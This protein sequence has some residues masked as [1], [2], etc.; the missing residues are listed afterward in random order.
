M[1][2]NRVGRWLM[3]SPL[4]A[5]LQRRYLMPTYERMG[6]KFDDARVLE[7][8]CGRGIGMDLIKRAGAAR[9]DG[10]DLD[11]VMVKLARRR[12]A[13]RML[14]FVADIAALPIPNATYD[15]VVDFGAIHLM[16]E[17]RTA[18]SEVARV[19]RPGGRFLFEQPAHRVYRLV[20][21]LSTSRRIPGGFTRAAFL[22]EL[23]ECGF[24]ETTLVRPRFL[25]LTGILGDVVGVAVR[26]PVSYGKA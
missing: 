3:N 2:M 13:G 11:P 19:V 10:A 9:V 20:M 1:R 7:V 18:V 5:C 6:A 15:V 21:P 14:V 16:P 17:W 24:R 4:R 23:A 26:S 22:A 8:G 12:L 25:A